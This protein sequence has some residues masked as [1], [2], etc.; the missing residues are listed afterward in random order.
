M[1]IPNIKKV[2]EIA[3]KTKIFM[4]LVSLAWIYSQP[5]VTAPVLGFTKLSQLE[6]AVKVFNV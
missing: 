2:K 1:D 4:T 3:D 6:E 5:I